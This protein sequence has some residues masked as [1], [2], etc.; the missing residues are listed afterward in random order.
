MGVLNALYFLSQWYGLGSRLRSHVKVFGFKN[1]I[2]KCFFFFAI[3][4]ESKAVVTLGD[5]DC[6]DGTKISGAKIYKNAEKA[7][8]SDSFQTCSSHS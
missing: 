5:P 4:S 8:Q 7:L 1:W 6:R 3:L 2:S